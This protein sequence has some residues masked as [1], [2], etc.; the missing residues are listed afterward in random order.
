[1]YNMRGINVRSVKIIFELWKI[2]KIKREKH[3]A[4]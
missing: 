3:Y 4:I 1:M 2:P